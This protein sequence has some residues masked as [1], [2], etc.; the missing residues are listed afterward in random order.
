LRLRFL[1]RCRDQLETL[2]A[3]AQQMPAAG[4]GDELVRT[5]HSLAGGG[6]TFG[7]PE[8]SECASDLETVLSEETGPDP[9]KVR[10][11]LD[12]LVLELERILG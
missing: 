3:A 7:F 5:A 4:S 2:K 8:L 12:A 9:A 6:G 1:G 11:A 10:A